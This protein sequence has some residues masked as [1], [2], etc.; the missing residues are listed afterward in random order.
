MI[1][2]IFPRELNAP[3][4]HNHNILLYTRAILMAKR[5]TFRHVAA[6]L[7]PFL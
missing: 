3:V 2:Y 1:L 5:E 4:N 7:T 6:V